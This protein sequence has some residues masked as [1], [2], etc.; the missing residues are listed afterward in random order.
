MYAAERFE[1]NT[2]RNREFSEFASICYEIAKTCFGLRVKMKFTATL[3]KK[4][5]Q[6]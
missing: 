5:F 4:S 6:V 1:R 2:N 3:Q